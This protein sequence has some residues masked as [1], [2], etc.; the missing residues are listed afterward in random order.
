[1][2]AYDLNTHSIVAGDIL[3]LTLYMQANHDLN[4]DY[5]MSVHLYTQAVPDIDSIEQDDMTLGNFTYP[6]RAWIPDLAVRNHFQ[7][8]IPD[9]IATNQ[10]YQLIAI[11]WQGD[12]TNRI[13]IQ[14]TILPI[15][16]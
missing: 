7:L 16:E 6:T 1:L 9:D 14:E 3:K 4:E 11:L 13:P 10:S 15:F 12:L 8:T 2:L 5:S